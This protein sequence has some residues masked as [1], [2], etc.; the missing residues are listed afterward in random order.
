[1]SLHLILSRPKRTKEEHGLEKH[2]AQFRSFSSGGE[3]EACRGQLGAGKACQVAWRT[4]YIKTV[5]SRCCVKF[6][7]NEQHMLNVWSEDL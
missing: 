3:V 5:A 2:T 6:V 4:K 1:M 7:M